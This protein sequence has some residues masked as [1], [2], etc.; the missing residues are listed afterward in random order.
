MLK[1]IIFAPALLALGA[2]EVSQDPADGGFYSGIVGVAGGGYQQRI[3]RL[4]AQLATSQARASAL[5]GEQ[6][7]LQAAAA[8]VSAQLANLRAQYAALQKVI[9]DQVAVLQA[10]GT[11]VDGSLL[12][13]VRAATGSAPGGRSDSA[14]LASLRIAIADARALSADLSRLS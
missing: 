13:R 8:S 6:L 14:R 10:S 5:A 4:E 3:D 12:V 2:C 7:R 1:F 9:N 11:N